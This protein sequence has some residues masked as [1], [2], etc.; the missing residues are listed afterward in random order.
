MS[1]P[2]EPSE[3]RLFRERV[4][5]AGASVLLF[6]YA[7]DLPA[8]L[9][10]SDDR[11]PTRGGELLVLGV[12]GLLAR[13]YSWCAN[14]AWLVGLWA[15]VG[16]RWNRAAAW[17]ALAVALAPLVFTLYLTGVS[18]ETKAEPFGG[19]RVGFY[20]WWGSMWVLL[21]GSLFLSWRARRLSAPA[22]SG[23]AR[24]AR[25]DSR[26]AGAGA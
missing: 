1:L 12:L 8:V 4:L 5:V 20:V 15:F 14:V 2:H 13:Q 19:V 23:R 6:A 16:R 9:L 22:P 10:S 25:R 17:S 7:C 18:S 3:P 11:L 21:A 24:S 26:S